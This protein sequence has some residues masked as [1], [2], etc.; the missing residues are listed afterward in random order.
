MRHCSIFS[1]TDQIEIFDVRA[2]WRKIW[3][4]LDLVWIS[5]VGVDPRS[6]VERKKRREVREE[7]EK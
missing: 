6:D 1:K 7:D 3:G 5:P 2:N 4:A